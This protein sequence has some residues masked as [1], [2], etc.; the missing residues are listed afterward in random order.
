M[1]DLWYIIVVTSAICGTVAY[2]YAKH[3][4]RNPLHWAA[5][6]AAL[7]LFTLAWVCRPHRRR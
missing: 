6:G 5:L 2:T 7:N 3:T 4:G 1:A